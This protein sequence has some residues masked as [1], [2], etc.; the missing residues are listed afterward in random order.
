MEYLLSCA[1]NLAPPPIMNQKQTVE[2]NNA[3]IMRLLNYD[4]DKYVMK[5]HHCEGKLIQGD[6]NNGRV[7]RT[8]FGTN[9]TK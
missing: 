4:R 6:R 5:S 1:G 9:G 3:D 2:R 7:T 8:R